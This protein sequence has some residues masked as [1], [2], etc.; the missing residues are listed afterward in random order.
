M[1]TKPAP[2]TNP[3]PKSNFNS[4][5]NCSVCMGGGDNGFI[6]EYLQLF[7]TWM[8]FLSGITPG[9]YMWGNMIYTVISKTVELGGFH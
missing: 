7:K 3:P 9:G 8:G 4:N 1:K 5:Y 6:M 2:K